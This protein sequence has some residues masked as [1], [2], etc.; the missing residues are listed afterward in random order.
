MER[1]LTLVSHQDFHLSNWQVL[2]MF[3]LGASLLNISLASETDGFVLFFKDSRALDGE[4]APLLSDPG[5]RLQEILRR[6][7]VTSVQ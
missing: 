7:L 6:F 1:P 4:C 5:R 2:D 3:V